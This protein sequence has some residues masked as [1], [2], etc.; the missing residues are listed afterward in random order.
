MF[1]LFCNLFSRVNVLCLPR[2]GRLRFG[3]PAGAGEK[4]ETEL[5]IDAPHQ[6]PAQP[7]NTAQSQPDKPLHVRSVRVYHAVK[8]DDTPVQ[9]TPLLRVAASYA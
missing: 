7:W 9:E 2:F 5:L 1:F 6:S 3:W 4:D 8:A